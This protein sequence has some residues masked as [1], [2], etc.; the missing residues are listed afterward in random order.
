MDEALKNHTTLRVGGMPRQFFY[1]HNV[2]ELQKT[3]KEARDYY[4]LG[5]GS[6]I[7]AE[8]TYLSKPV[9][10]LSSMPIYLDIY[11]EEQDVVYVKATANVTKQGLL[12][13][14]MKK[15]LTGGEFLAGIPG[16]LGGGWAMNAGTQLGD[17]A[18]L[19]EELIV[20]NSQAETKVY[21]KE[22]LSFDYRKLT[23]KEGELIYSGILKFKKANQEDIH[24][25]VKEIIQRRNAMQPVTQANCGCIFKNPFVDGK[26][27]SAGKLIEMAG[28]KKMQIGAAR[29]SEKH[30]NF[31]VNLGGATSRNI[32]DLIS[33]VKEAVKK[34]F[35]VTLEEEVQIWT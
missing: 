19:T 12:Q 10:K 25:K 33:H 20:L 15:G 5:G 35:S 29:V 23:L 16:N 9:L 32:F 13:F 14:C 22:D 30:A 11:K 8:D 31:I 26:R 6:N 2:F 28:L 34:Q 7:L 4:V 1:P 17:F 21:S 24:N 27:E 18:S 3:L